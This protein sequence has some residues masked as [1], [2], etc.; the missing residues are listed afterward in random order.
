[1]P[2]QMDWLRGGL[3]DSR[4]PN[5]IIGLIIDTRSYTMSNICF[6]ICGFS[7]L[8][9]VLLGV[10]KDYFL[11]ILVTHHWDKC[12]S[13]ITRVDTQQTTRTYDNGVDI[14][15]TWKVYATYTYNSIEYK[16]VYTGLDTPTLKEGNTIV[17][18]VNPNDPSEFQVKRNIGSIIPIAVIS[19]LFVLLLLAVFA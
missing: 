19:I 10:C 1:M 15:Q 4:L 8:L 2:M 6:A 16:D 3:R 17:L 13:T 18:Y 5:T 12:I 14:H 9:I 7:V 11:Y